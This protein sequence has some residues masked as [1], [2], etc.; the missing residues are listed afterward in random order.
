MN[1]LSKFYKYIWRYRRT[2]IAGSLLIIIAQVLYNLSTYYIKFLTDAVN[3]PNTDPLTYVNIIAGF[4][5]V[6]VVGMVVG[7]FAWTVTD[8][9]IL[10]GA[11]DLR[12]EVLTHL[13]DLD[14]A[15]HANKKSGSLISMI[16]RGD[17]AFFS[18][19]HEINRELLM[20]LV[21]FLFIVFAFAALDYRLTLVVLISVLIMLSL[22]RYLLARNI[23]ARRYFNKV[24]D[25]ISGI[26]ADNLI[27]FETV[28]FFAKEK[29]EHNRLIDKFKEW[30]R[31]VWSY[32]YSF[33][34]I[35]VVTSTLIIISMA[36][37]FV[38]C[39]DLMQ[40]GIFNNGDFILV[41]TFTV[42]FYPQMYNLIFRLREIAK[43]H[44]DL[45]KYLNVL[46]LKPDVQDKH[47]ARELGNVVGRIEF[48]DIEFAYKQ[49]N[50]IIKGLNLKIEPNQSVALV[51]TS[52]AGKSTLVKLLLRF[53]DIQKGS[54]L[55]DGI[56]ISDVTKSSLRAQIGLVP[57]EPVLF[58][59]TIGYN[60]AYP[61][62]NVS[63]QR[64]IEAARLANLNDFIE[65]LPD[66]YETEVGE[67][68][69]KLSG[70][71]KQRLAIARVFLADT[72]VV[73]FDEATSQLDSFS[74]KLIQDA[75]WRIAKNKTT[76]II[77]H[78]LSTVMR[79]DRIIVIDKGLIAEEGTHQEL[80]KKKGGLYK[81][82]WDMQRGGLL[83]E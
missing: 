46:D 18:F 4:I 53:Y 81:S 62:P 79:A 69:I 5:G 57:Q 56:D 50:D 42:K 83:V 63:K 22:T 66:K 34:E 43:N 38:I 13:H 25:D 7:V 21:D 26:I 9:Y 75:F 80:T 60:I 28:K 23:K 45:E 59:D 8:I 68:G 70:G 65:K 52:G 55:V 37:I 2:F 10:Q 41:I 54:I 61:N 74:E 51:G 1:I 40:K 73:V 12:I 58:N 19:N 31:R 72:P 47:N 27:N 35:E 64:I 14:F 16:R 44:T 49:G 3:T 29:F 20:I 30:Y 82:L 76:I 36:V 77:A 67:R 6:Q 15:Y 48:K 78:R 39:L 17:G 71:Q 32:T 24:E 11:R 33:R